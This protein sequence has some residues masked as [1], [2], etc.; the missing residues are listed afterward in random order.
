MRSSSKR[1]S[2]QLAQNR[3]GIELSI[4]FL[5]VL[6]L[7]IVILGLGIYLYTRINVQIQNLVEDV[8]QEAQEDIFRLL[9][10][11]QNEFVFIPNVIKEVERGDVA[12]FPIGIRADTA[13]CGGGKDATF[14]ITMSHDIIV[15]GNNKEIVPDNTLKTS[16]SSWYLA[17]PKT[18]TL[19]N[20]EKVVIDRPI[21]AGTD[22]LEGYTYGFDVKISCDNINRYGGKS[23]KLLVV[24]R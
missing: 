13:Q 18:V 15:D 19:K 10:K 14:T 20:N 16:I 21:L 11:Q 23:H 7:S 17:E 12:H 9:D 1:F 6:I 8:S 24:V 5:V 3:G 2:P 4:N 22:A